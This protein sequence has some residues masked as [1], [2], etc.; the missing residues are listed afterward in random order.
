MGP[1]A[2]NSPNLTVTQTLTLKPLIPKSMQRTAMGGNMPNLMG[3]HVPNPM[4]GC[5]PNP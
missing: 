4:E 3:G 5:M 2:T 1:R